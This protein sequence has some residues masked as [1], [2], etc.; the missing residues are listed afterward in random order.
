MPSRTPHL[1]TLITS[2]SKK[3]PDALLHVSDDELIDTIK[4]LVHGPDII[5]LF[6]TLVEIGYNHL[7]IMAEECYKQYSENSADFELFKYM[8]SIHMFDEELYTTIID[9]TPDSSIVDLISVFPWK[10][11]S[12]EQS[13][14]LLNIINDKF[15]EIDWTEWFGRSIIRL[16]GHARYND[17]RSHTLHTMRHDRQAL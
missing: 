13:V 4:Q 8:T 15:T 14:V 12:L 2:A 6:K 9:N 16:V 17:L 10:T 1:I 3:L 5:F 11:A 7:I